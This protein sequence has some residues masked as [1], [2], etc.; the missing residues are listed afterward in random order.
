MTKF[1]VSKIKAVYKEA[2]A[3]GKI[4]YTGVKLGQQV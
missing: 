2:L 3:A 1:D 4:V